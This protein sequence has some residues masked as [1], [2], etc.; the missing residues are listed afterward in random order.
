MDE[1]PFHGIRAQEGEQDREEGRRW[2]MVRGRHPGPATG[3]TGMCSELLR[4]L[5]GD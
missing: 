1:G 2:D 3:E 5:R 4:G